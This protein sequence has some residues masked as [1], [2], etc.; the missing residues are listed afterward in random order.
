M[1]KREPPQSFLFE[2]NISHGWKMWSKRFDFFLM[3]TESDEKS[4]K[5]KTWILL[6][7]IG[8]KGREIYDTFQ[9]ATEGDCV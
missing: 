2:G 5:V 8:P 7:C 1:D 3:A 4:N 9:F 6:S